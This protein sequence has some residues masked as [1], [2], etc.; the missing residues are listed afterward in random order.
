MIIMSNLGSEQF[1]YK[2]LHTGV[3]E[4]EYLLTMQKLSSKVKSSHVHRKSLSDI[5]GSEIVGCCAMFA[6][7]MSIDV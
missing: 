7:P 5:V 3:H 2:A 4:M 6:A 1:S